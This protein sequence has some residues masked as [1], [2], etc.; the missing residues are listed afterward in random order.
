MIIVKNVTVYPVTSEPIV[1]GAVAWE[2]G[3]II[4]VGKPDNLGPEG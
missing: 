1:D 2:D 4:A 3:K